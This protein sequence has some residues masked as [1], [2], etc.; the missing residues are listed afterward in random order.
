MKGPDDPSLYSVVF[1]NMRSNHKEENDIVLEGETRRPEDAQTTTTEERNDILSTTDGNEESGSKPPRNS[2]L[3][4]HRGE[5]IGISLR[6]NMT[7]GTWNIRGLT[8]GKLQI[9][10]AEMA[11]CNT[12]ILGIAEHWLSG[13][14]RFQT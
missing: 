6:R 8:T 5:Q 2:D 7:I 13:Q 14:G 1:T 10:T 3:D 4:D 12:K 11:R 9:L